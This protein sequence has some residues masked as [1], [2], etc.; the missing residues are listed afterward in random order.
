[1]KHSGEIRERV[2]LDDPLNKAPANWRGAARAVKTKEA[3]NRGGLSSKVSLPAALRRAL[4]GWHQAPLHSWQTDRRPCRE[5]P[6]QFPDWSWLV[7]I[8]GGWR[9]A[10]PD[11]FY[12]AL[13]YSQSR[14]PIPL[15]Y[16][17]NIGSRSVANF[18]PRFARS[19]ARPW[20]P[21]RL[22]AS[23]MKTKSDQELNLLMERGQH[24]SAVLFLVNYGHREDEIRTR[25]HKG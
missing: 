14:S 3:A 9:L 8:S 2:R 12:Q 16:E 15:S 1:M 4:R 6:R 21:S 25:I 19:S 10:P 22:Q 5:G 24:P 18:R 7:Q 17:V 23:K 11:T 13:C 20:S